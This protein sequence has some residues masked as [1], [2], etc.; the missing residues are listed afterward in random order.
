MSIEDPT[1]QL[2]VRYFTFLYSTY[3]PSDAAA[4]NTSFKMLFLAYGVRKNR[5]SLPNKTRFPI[6]KSKKSSQCAHA[7]TQSPKRSRN[8][9]TMHLVTHMT[10]VKTSSKKIYWSGRN[11]SLINSLFWGIHRPNPSR[12]PRRSLNRPYW[13][14]SHLW[15][16]YFQRHLVS[17]RRKSSHAGH[18]LRDY[19]RLKT[20]S[21]T[22]LERWKRTSLSS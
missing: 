22:S 7:A 10:T 19:C 21:K 2:F 13:T 16:T 18:H 14:G 17:P 9:Q 5:T 15:T 8:N 3:R 20:S 4:A 1:S 12:R 6:S 11:L